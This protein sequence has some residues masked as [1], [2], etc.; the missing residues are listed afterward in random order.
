M[1]VQVPSGH[2]AEF[3]IVDT[4]YQPSDREG[5]QF[6]HGSGMSCACTISMTAEYLHLAPEHNQAAV[7]RLD[8]VAAPV[9]QSDLAAKRL[10]DLH[11]KHYATAWSK[12]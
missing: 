5:C 12:H 2:Y 9:I 11:G 6:T 4:H 8:S 7:E 3:G 1:G 10:I